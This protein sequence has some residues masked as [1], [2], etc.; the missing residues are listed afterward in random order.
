ML[1]MMTK[2]GAAAVAL[3]FMTITGAMA[4]TGQSVPWQIGMQPSNSPSMDDLV[5]F[6]TLLM[7]VITLITLFVLALLIWVCYRYSAKNN[8]VASKTTHHVGIEIAWSVIPVLILV[9]IAIPSFRILYSQQDVS[10]PDITIKAIG[11]QWF[12]SYEYTDN[13]GF[14]FDQLMLDEKDRAKAI[15]AGGKADENP[16][17]LAVDNE[18]V[19]PVGKKIKINLTASDVIHAWFVPAFAVNQDAVPG[20]M[21]SAWFKADKEGVFFGQCSQLCGKDHAFMPIKVRIVSQAKFEEWLVTAKK[22]YA[23]A[24]DVQTVAAK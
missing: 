5:W 11:K 24:F 12:W 15:A 13:G 22:K 6:H 2:K 17:L 3:F 8:P 7:W 9:M 4:V 23:S 14:G 10:N 16:R 1:S 18:L 20:R 21:N 19:L